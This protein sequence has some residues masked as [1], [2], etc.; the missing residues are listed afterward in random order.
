MHVPDVLRAPVCVAVR[1]CVQTSVYF[2]ARFK[3]KSQYYLRVV[4]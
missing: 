4:E 2:N 3:E 1:Y